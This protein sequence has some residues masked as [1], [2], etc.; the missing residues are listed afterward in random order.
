MLH[1]EKCLSLCRHMRKWNILIWHSY[2]TSSSH[3]RVVVCWP[4]ILI[5]EVVSY[6]HVPPGQH[7]IKRL[8]YWSKMEQPSYYGI[9][10]AHIRYSR[11]VE[12]GAKVLYSEITALTNERGYCFASNDYFS[13]K[14]GVTPKTITT[15]VQSLERA[16][17][18][19]V[20]IDQKRDHKRRIYVSLD[21]AIRDGIDVS[22]CSL[23]TK[24][25][26]IKA[27]ERSDNEGVPPNK[28]V[29]S[30]TQKCVEAPNKNVRHNT[31]VEY[32]LS[33]ERDST[34]DAVS[35]AEI[36]PLENKG[37]SKVAKQVPLH[38]FQ[39]SVLAGDNAA[40]LLREHFQIA[41]GGKY[42]HGDFQY[43]AT[44]MRRY[45]VEVG[46]NKRGIASLKFRDWFKVW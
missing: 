14:Y 17:F 10:P 30:S 45:Y 20:D 43:Y 21:A 40:Q 9:L 25:P 44:E 13:M 7:T 26:R 23:L 33:N 37:K 8:F 29:S 19:I 38:L 36:L 16:T 5:L 1:I 35:A 34:A 2:K 28:N 31:I 24:M 39:D 46:P 3:C 11:E 15:W 12:F 42:R 4:C 41:S 27:G 32:S 18:V 22:K 6:V